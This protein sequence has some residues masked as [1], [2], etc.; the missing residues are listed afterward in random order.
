MPPT[1]VFASLEQVVILYCRLSERKQRQTRYAPQN[2]D[3]DD[4]GCAQRAL[5]ARCRSLSVHSVQKSNR[6]P[7]VR[8]Q[9]LACVSNQ[10]V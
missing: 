2:A 7:S 6:W 10:L 5:F 1:K 9:P 4:R 3:C 8:V